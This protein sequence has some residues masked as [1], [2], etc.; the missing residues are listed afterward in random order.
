MPVKIITVGNQKG[1]VGKS[2]T[3]IN[4]A[5]ALGRLGKKVLIIDAD[6]QANTTETLLLRIDKRLTNNLVAVLDAPNGG[7]TFSSAACETTNPNVWIVPNTLDCLLWE[8]RA[9]G[10]FDGVAG[11]RRILQSDPSLERLYDYIL[12]DTPPNLGVMVNNSLMISDYV[13]VP[14]PVTDQFAMDGFATFLSVIARAK[15]ENTKLTVLGVLLTLHD[16]RNAYCKQNRQ[17]LENFFQSKSIN[18]FN[19][20]IRV[21][22]DLSRALGKRRTIFEFDAK[23][24]GAEDYMNFAKEIEDS[25]G[26]KNGERSKETR[27]AKAI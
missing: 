12:I 8:Q 25:I 13:I 11:F 20:V 18:Y 27:K 26:T 6:A 3:V 1:G 17:S 22:V 14:I 4:T 2:M 24:S 10:T 16:L 15:V 19:T 5:D 23:K 7:L 9:G 21:N